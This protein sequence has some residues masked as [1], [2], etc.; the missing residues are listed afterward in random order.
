MWPQH[1][2]LV[3]LSP[4]HR[5]CHTSLCARPQALSL[6]PLQG[7]CPELLLHLWSPWLDT[8]RLPVSPSSPGSCS[9]NVNSVPLLSPPLLCSLR[10][11]PL[12]DIVTFL[13]STLWDEVPP[14]R[15]GETSDAF[16]LVRGTATARMIIKT[17]NEEWIHGHRWKG[18][19]PKS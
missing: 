4:R 14:P 13:S 11:L 9:P 3:H 10:H 19:I 7:S 5:S 12:P 1:A 2:S 6:P 8:H 15:K 17:T 16:T 18:N